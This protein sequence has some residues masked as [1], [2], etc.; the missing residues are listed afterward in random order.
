M[1]CQSVIAGRPEQRM[2]QGQA[3]DSSKPII[4]PGLAMALGILAVSTSALFTRYAQAYAPSLVIAAHRLLFASLVL[5]PLTLWRY[6]P[7]LRRLRATQIALSAAAGALLAAHF[8]TWIT[9][10][11]YTSVA[12]SVVLVSTAPLFVALLAPPL[13]GESITPT[14]LAGLLLALLG[15]A[16]VGLSDACSWQEGLRCTTRQA[17]TRGALH[18]DMLAIIGAVTVAGYLIIG[19]RMRSSLSLIPYITIAYSAAA[20]VLIIA[21]LAAGYPPT[22]Y[23]AQAY[24]WFGLL[25]LLPQLLAHSTYN[26]ALRYLSAAF[27]SISLLAEPIG[28]TLLAYVLLGEKPG[29]LMLCGSALILAGIFIASRQGPSRIPSYGKPDIR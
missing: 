22:G 23:A 12:S 10:L 11:E 9:S 26:W 4:P 16:I 27:V 5:W 14:V 13:L 19:R 1:T 21:M 6:K 20:V 7:E 8:A 18:G 24:I 2:Q 15:S 3:P 28:S 25:A 29:W 17:A